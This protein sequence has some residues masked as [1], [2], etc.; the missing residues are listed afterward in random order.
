MGVNSVQ[1]G[2]FAAAVA[3]SRTDNQTD[4][5]KKS[6]R[7][8]LVEPGSDPEKLDKEQL[9]PLVNTLNQFMQELTA[10]IRFQMHDKTKR[11][12]VQVVDSKDGTVLK[13]FPPHEML[14]TIAKISEYVGALLDKRA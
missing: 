6:D 14:D 12:I 2:Q 5:G 10:G 1:S 8:I 11:L 4:S 13:E 7:R 3:A 9:T